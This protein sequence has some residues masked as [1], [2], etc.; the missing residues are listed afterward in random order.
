MYKIQLFIL[1][2]LQELL[3]LSYSLE[4]ILTGNT[5]QELECP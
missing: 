2:Y 5:P 4:F 1:N 3:I